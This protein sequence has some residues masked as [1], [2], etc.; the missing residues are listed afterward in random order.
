MLIAPEMTYYQIAAYPF[1]LDLPT[2]AT[3]FQHTLTC[4]LEAFRLPQIPSIPI[5]AHPPFEHTN[6]HGMMRCVTEGDLYRVEIRLDEASAG[7]DPVRL[8]EAFEPQIVNQAVRESPLYLW[9]HGACLVRGDDLILLVARTGTGKTTLSL[10]LLAHGYRLLTDDI[11][12]MNLQTGAFL[13]LPRCPK[14]REPAPAYLAAAGFDLEQDAR[15]MGHYVLLPPQR[16]QSQPVIGPPR[17]IYCLQ[18]TADAPLGA[19]ELSLTDGLLALLP[20]S[21]LLALDPNFEQSAA[22]FAQTQFIAMNLHHY[23]DDLAYIAQ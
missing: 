14:Y 18:R 9:I 22:W 1:Q 13:P 15:T 23:P 20:Q 10:G 3:S 7:I 16:L 12:L 4:V 19:R 5:T 8:V 11:I 17:R 6:R 21:N 2:A